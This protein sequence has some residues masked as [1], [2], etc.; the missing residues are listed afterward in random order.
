MEII[1]LIGSSRFRSAFVREGSRLEK[2]GNLV[3]CM[4]FF[5]HFDKIEVS[6]E[7]RLILEK[8]DRY[9]ISL[10]SR[11]F[12]I[13]CR[14]PYCEKCN[15]FR[16]PEYKK[17]SGN[18]IFNYCKDK[19]EFTGM[20]KPYIG[21]STRKEITYAIEHDRR[22]DFLFP[23][24]YVSEAKFDEEFSLAESIRLFEGDRYIV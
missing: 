12:V 7:E 3:L 21:E 11:V 15:M 1:T 18:Q 14:L 4:T 9:R 24:D 19:C 20:F 22:V 10:C 2:Q 17:G 13:N 5:Q 23:P 6:D 16:I 8:V